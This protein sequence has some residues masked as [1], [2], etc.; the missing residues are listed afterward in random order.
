MQTPVSMLMPGLPNGPPK[1]KVQSKFQKIKKKSFLVT[2]E[3]T[4]SSLPQIFS[5]ILRRF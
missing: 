5:R 1:V 2:H 4:P 3:I